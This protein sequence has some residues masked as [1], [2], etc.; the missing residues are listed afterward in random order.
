MSVAITAIVGFGG[1][2]LGAIA[3]FLGALYIDT[4]RTRRTRIGIVRALILEL[5]ENGAAAAQVLY[6]GT[7]ATEYSS[8]TWRAA[9]FELAQ[10]L[11]E[12]LYKHIALLYMMLPAVKDLSSHPVVTKGTK[13]LLDTWLEDTKKAMDG[14]WQLPEASKFRPERAESLAR[15]EDVAK[16]AK[17][18][19]EGTADKATQS[20]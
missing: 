15:L 20:E 8:E 2:L 6:A 17:S 7:R 5:T 9:N 1:A 19:G 18:E 13:A 10:F 11:D 3:G 4:R 14:L 16:K 12:A